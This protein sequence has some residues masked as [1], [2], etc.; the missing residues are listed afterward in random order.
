VRSTSRQNVIVHCS[1][2]STISGGHDSVFED[3]LIMA[4]PYDGGQCFNMGSFYEGHGDILQRN[5]CLVGLGHKMASGCGD[6]SCAS[7]TPESDESQQIVGHLWGGCENSAVV[8]SKN[9]YF[10]PDGGAK[11]GCQDD[12]FSL[13]EL[14]AKYGMEKGSTH[15]KLPDEETMLKWARQIT[16]L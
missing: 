12:V 1:H 4:F 16:I 10:T 14:Q 6:P 11:I 9:Q 5:R 2:I 13:E 15:S 8:L 7:S 3:N